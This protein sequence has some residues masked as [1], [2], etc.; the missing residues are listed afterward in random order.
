MAQPISDVLNNRVVLVVIGVLVGGLV[1]GVINFFLQRGQD[2]RRFEHERSMQQQRWEQETSTRREQ[3]DREDQERKGQWDREDKARERQWSRE[4]EV[5]QQRWDREDRLRNYNERR[6]AYMQ[7]E[8]ATNDAH[9]A[10]ATIRS[11]TDEVIRSLNE[12]VQASAAIRTIAPMTVWYS[13]QALVA[14]YTEH[15]QAIVGGRAT[16][17]SAEKLKKRHMLFAQLAQHDLGLVDAK[18]KIFKTTLKEW[19][20]ELA[21]ESEY[22]VLESDR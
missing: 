21:P 5:Q 14:A 4:S 13:A 8:K 9:L 2:R 16:E 17:E 20:D 18:D 7:L 11:N 3:W 22:P 12:A 10:R 6:D 1:T 15:I 19:L